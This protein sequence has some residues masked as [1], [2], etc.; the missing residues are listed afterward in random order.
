MGMT[1]KQ[2]EELYQASEGF[3]IRDEF[4]EPTGLLNSFELLG[5]FDG[6][7]LYKRKKNKKDESNTSI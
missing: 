6:M 3:I 1:K 5:F 4:G 2:Y 7:N